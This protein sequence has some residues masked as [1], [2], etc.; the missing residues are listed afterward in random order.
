MLRDL[1]KFLISCSKGVQDDL[2]S[3]KFVLAMTT[4][5]TVFDFKIS[6]TFTKW[7]EVFDGS[8]YLSILN[9]SGITPLYR[10]VNKDDSQRV[11]V[12]FQGEE[13]VALKLFTNPKGKEMIEA[14]G[15]IYDSTTISQWKPEDIQPKKSNKLLISGIFIAL[16]S[17]FLL[18]YLLRENLFNLI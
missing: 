10:G 3:T 1:N 12:I 13:G 2:I 16:T 6:N 11:I 7:S 8:E 14:S 9:E 15:H 18:I 5:T 4:E 17:T